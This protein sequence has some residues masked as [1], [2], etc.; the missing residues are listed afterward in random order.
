V[1]IKQL[2]NQRRRVLRPNS[3]P[4]FENASFFTNIVESISIILIPM[5]CVRMFGRITGRMAACGGCLC[6]HA[7][8]LTVKVAVPIISKVRPPLLLPGYQ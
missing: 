4:P 3:T 8:L 7:A 6:R 5:A 1:T 2:G